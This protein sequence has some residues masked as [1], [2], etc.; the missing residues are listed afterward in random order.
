MVKHKTKKSNIQ[1]TDKNYANITV[2]FNNTIVTI[3]NMLGQ[4]IAWSSAGKMGFKGSKKNAPYPAKQASRDCAE[5]ALKRGVKSVIVRIKGLGTSREHAIRGLSEV[6]L[7][8]TRIQDRT[9]MAYNGCRSPK[10]R[11]L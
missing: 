5:K 4:T 2:S 8:I 11:H 10:K 6:G 7:K 3:T 1:I 9:P